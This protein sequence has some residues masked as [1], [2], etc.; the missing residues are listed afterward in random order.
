MWFCWVLWLHLV[1]A[2]IG[3][4]ESY[5]VTQNG[6]DK[7]T[8]LGSIR[9]ISPINS[10]LFISTVSSLQSVNVGRTRA[11]ERGS[12]FGT[13]QPGALLNTQAIDPLSVRE[14]PASQNDIFDEPS[15]PAH[16]SNVLPDTGSRAR[17]AREVATLS[18]KVAS[19]PLPA[20][21]PHSRPPRATA[22]DQAP[23]LFPPGTPTNCQCMTQLL[24]DFMSVHQWSAVTIILSEDNSE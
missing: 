22:A 19:T 3:N 4:S 10:T 5:K 16:Q 23:G 7:G 14:G 15:L 2:I 17:I 24:M 18:R 13:A 12:G 20:S 1:L 9:I 8:S 11:K 21:Q 6:T